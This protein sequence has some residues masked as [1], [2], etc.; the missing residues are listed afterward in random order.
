MIDGDIVI[1]IKDFDIVDIYKYMEALSKIE[2]GA[3]TQITVLRDKEEI[4][5]D[6]QF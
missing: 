4:V 5:L 1:K 6:V 2:S 3:K